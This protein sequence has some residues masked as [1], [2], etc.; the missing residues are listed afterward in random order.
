VDLLRSVTFASALELVCALEAIE[1]AAGKFDDV[2]L[3][4]EESAT[5]SSRPVKKRNDSGFDIEP[6]RR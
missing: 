2:V 5:V 6:P 1:L 3:E 4:H